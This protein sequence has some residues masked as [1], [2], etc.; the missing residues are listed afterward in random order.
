MVLQD[1]S[2]VIVAFAE[3]FNGDGRLGVAKS[4]DVLYVSSCPTVH[5]SSA[6][7]VRRMS[8]TLVESD[9]KTKADDT[10]SVDGGFL[11]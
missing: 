9:S 5:R 3:V 7:P 11:Y 1:Y 4:M 10:R 2:A 8:P 6:H